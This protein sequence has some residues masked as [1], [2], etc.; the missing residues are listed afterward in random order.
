MKE[1]NTK[2]TTHTAHEKIHTHTHQSVHIL[3]AELNMY[4]H[5]NNKNEAQYMNI[6]LDVEYEHNHQTHT[7]NKHYIFAQSDC[8]PHEIFQ[9]IQS[10]ARVVDHED[11]V[12]DS[13]PDSIIR[14]ICA[15]NICSHINH[16]NIRALELYLRKKIGKSACILVNALCD[17]TADIDDDHVNSSAQIVALK[18][19]SQKQ[20]SIY[21]KVSF[22]QKNN[23]V[24]ITF[25]SHKYKCAQ[26]TLC[27]TANIP[28]T[29]IHICNDKH[30]RFQL[31][32]RIL[33]DN[34][35][36]R[37]YIS[38]CASLYTVAISAS[39]KLL[40]NKAL[41]HDDKRQYVHTYKKRTRVRSFMRKKRKYGQVYNFVYIRNNKLN[42]RLDKMEDRIHTIRDRQCVSG[43]IYRKL[44]EESD[45]DEA[46]EN[47]C[48]PEVIVTHDISL[49]HAIINDMREV[50]LFCMFLGKDVYNLQI[51][52]DQLISNIVTYSLLCVLANIHYVTNN[53][54]DI[55]DSD[56]TNDDISDSDGYLTDIDDS[57]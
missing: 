49:R 28:Q 20:Y 8:V 37:L 29:R 34:V 21:T 19:L 52:H 24:S 39:T 48:A 14:L 23:N 10:I 53:A 27:Y 32:N 47:T 25:D 41:K 5:D 42:R 13:L 46:A 22:A 35:Y 31:M 4:V 30:N 17:Y 26:T 55:S 51:L 2:Q 50:R 16:T 7:L 44:Y 45:G 12:R 36:M 43:K 56:D 6:N 3:T 11:T 40:Y 1:L 33:N 54:V 38:L 57:D 15:N 18:I 9:V